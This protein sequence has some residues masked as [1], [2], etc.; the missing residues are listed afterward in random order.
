MDPLADEARSRA[1]LDA[2]AGL[3]WRPIGRDD[4]PAVAT[5]YA[6]AAAHDD[7]PE[8]MS[9]E[10]LQDYW[11]AARSR[12]EVDTL[13]AR[14]EAGRAAAVA[15][16][17]CNRA[18]TER[19][20]VHLGG[21]VRPDRR[22]EGVGR[23]VLRWELDHAHAWDH[24][25]REEGFGPLVL[26][27][28]APVGQD[29]VRDLAQ[30]HGLELERYFFEMS[31]PLEPL[32]ALTPIEGISL[33]DWDPARSSEVHR[34]LDLAFGDHWGHVDRT[35]EM[36]GETLTSHAFRP[37]WTVLAIDEATEIV[38][39]AAISCAYE[40]DWE[41]E[42]VR[43]GYT[44]EVGVLRSHRGRGIASALLVESMRRFAG[45]GLDTAGLGVDAANP[46]GALR[47]YEG[48]GYAQRASTCV[49]QLTV[50]P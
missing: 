44:D 24:A 7:N 13:V 1:A 9:L 32:P 35:E 27:L 40:Q 15:W 19:R 45:A 2:I 14:D 30:R 46:S 21:V 26:R 43:E 23:A 28:Y 3:T 38:V 25:T 10:T 17:G 8:R 18:V 22:G 39:G 49:H 36:W 37:A 42:G 12:P 33:V 29:D 48:L 50:A 11:D 31:R 41:V 34:V 5:L 20:G 47:L 16:S 6:A 4:L